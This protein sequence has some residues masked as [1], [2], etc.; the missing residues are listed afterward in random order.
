MDRGLLGP[1]RGEKHIPRLMNVFGGLEK[2]FE[3]VNQG[4]KL[5]FFVS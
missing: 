4:K 5:D 1:L 3:E 2:V